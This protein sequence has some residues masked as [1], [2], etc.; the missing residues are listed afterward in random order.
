MCKQTF[1]K[2]DSYHIEWHEIEGQFH[3]HCVV[4]VWNKSVLKEL[5][6]EF[7]KLRQFISGLGYEC[8][9]SIS[10]NPKFCELFCGESIGE[11]NGKEVMMWVI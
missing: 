6:K 8:F 11:Q 5:Y 10:P 2:T 9:Y 7:V 3:I 1:S 4:S